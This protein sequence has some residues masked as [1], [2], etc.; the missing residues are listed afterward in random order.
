M[1]Q[2]TVCGISDARD[3]ATLWHMPAL[4]L[5]ERFGPY[6][7]AGLSH[8]QELVISIPTGHVQLRRQLDPLILYNSSQYSFRTADSA[9][10]RRGVATFLNFLSE[11]ARGRRFRSAVDIGGN[12][13][14]MA[15]SLAS[16]ADSVSVVEP[17]CGELDGKT[18]DGV[19]VIG[20]FIE[21]VNLAADLP[22]PDLVVCRHTLEHLS[23]PLD[24]LRAWFAQCRPDCLY[25]VEIPCFA[26]LVEAQRFDAVFHQHFH[27]FDLVA[28][29][30]LLWESGGRAI[31]HA[32]DR[33]GPCGG[34]LLVAFERSA[35]SAQLMPQVDLEGRIAHIQRRMI[36][37]RTQM[38]LLAELLRALPRPVFGYGAGLMLAT[39]GYHLKTD[40]SELECILDDDPAR[41]GATY[42][43][44][45]VRVADP[46]QAPPPPNSCYLITS[47]ENVRPIYRRILDLQPRRVLVPPLA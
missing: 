16:I 17:L 20:R 29:N 21:H 18:I 45:P 35:A 38:E 4:P 1:Q 27:Y 10:A 30:H 12:D 31:A 46:K 7:P 25:I 2:V 33:Q 5:T 36:A 43:N 41:H 44:V 23:R 32:F 39:L 13:L 47:L 8:D 28:I 24:V 19:H 14:F 15:R 40:F 3:F 34:A 6:A 42:E 11:V 9:K 26:N 37:Y 22:A